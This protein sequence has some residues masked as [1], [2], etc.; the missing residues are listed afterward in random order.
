MGREASSLLSGMSERVKSNM[1]DYLVLLL[2]TDW[3]LPYWTEIGIDI[4][5]D[6]KVGIQR[7]CR[8]IIDEILDG[9]DSFYLASFSEERKQMTES[10]LLALLRQWGAERE[11]A[12]T[13]NEWRNL[14]HGE[15]SAVVQCAMLNAEVPSADGSGEVPCLEFAI[16]VEVV[17]AWEAHSLKASVF[18]DICLG[19]KTTWDLRTQKLLTSPRTL[20]NQLWR[21][22]LDHRF[23]AFWTDLQKRLSSQ[24]LQELVSWY[25][26]MVKEKAHEDRPDLIPSYIS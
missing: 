5:D 25:R 21:V 14:S 10:K 1:T 19:S 15:L 7:G 20:V 8:Q 17:K 26:A 3:F 24:Q 13:C 22:L 2:S 4:T 16:R 6:E 23:R 9:A 11:M 12:A 18:R